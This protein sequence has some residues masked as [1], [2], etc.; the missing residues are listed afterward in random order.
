[1]KSCQYV[2]NEDETIE[3]IATGEYSK[4]NDPARPTLT[5]RQKLSEGLSGY[6]LIL[7]SM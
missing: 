7:A 5:I 2:I 4:I 1:M 6:I 3:G